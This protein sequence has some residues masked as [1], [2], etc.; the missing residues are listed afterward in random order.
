MILAAFVFALVGANRLLQSQNPEY[1]FGELGVY[2][3][4]SGFETISCKSEC[5]TAV[6]FAKLF[7]LEECGAD[8]VDCKDKKNLGN[9]RGVCM[10]VNMSAAKP[11]LFVAKRKK[12]KANSRLLCKNVQP[13]VTTTT[14]MPCLDVP[15]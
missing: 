7:G 1:A 14:A 2:S 10:G 8:G 4:P 15:A 11:K 9:R 5:R 3:C 13:P 12:F 6:A